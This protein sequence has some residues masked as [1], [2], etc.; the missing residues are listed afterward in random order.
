[1]V[2]SI[3]A[4]AASG[5]AFAQAS[6]FYG[7]IGLGKSEA[8]LNS[9]F[10]PAAPAT[11][12]FDEKDTAWKLFA[13]Y[14]FAPNFAAEL[15]FADLGKFTTSQSTGLG[16]TYKASSW[17]V[18]GVAS[19]PISGGFSL[20]GKLGLAYNQAK[21]SSTDGESAKKTKSDLMWG[22]GAQYDFTPRLGLRAEYENF[23]KFGDAFQTTGSQTGRA[24]VDM[25]S[26]SI[27]SRF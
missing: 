2:S 21:L 17:T 18:A 27:M 6:G 9:E 10:N 4:L 14:K 13:G 1:M 12:T 5:S 23:G 15:G 19:Y 16:A 25:F 22:L 7:G 8:E 24:K 20:L 3:V 11:A 26:L